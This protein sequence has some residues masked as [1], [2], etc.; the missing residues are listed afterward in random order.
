[1]LQERPQNVYELFPE[2]SSDIDRRI[3]HSE[4][5]IKNWVIGGILANLIALIF[6][7]IPL[8]YYLG[9]IQA[10]SSQAL[11]T[12]Q[13]TSAELERRRDWMLDRQL[14]EQSM[15]SWAAQHGYVPSVRRD[16]R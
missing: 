13:S 12:I 5:R 7:A 11:Q 2:L 8:V 16:R 4:T 15:E 14:W 10:Q 3:V 1:M 6:A 9:Q